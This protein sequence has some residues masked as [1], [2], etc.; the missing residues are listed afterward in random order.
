MN[1]VQPAYLH[2][3]HSDKLYAIIRSMLNANKRKHADVQA[4]RPVV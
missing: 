2:T 3:C 4:H 1:T